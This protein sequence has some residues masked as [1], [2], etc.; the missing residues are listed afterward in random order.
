MCVGLL[1]GDGISDRVEKNV[2]YIIMLKRILIT[3]CIA[4]ILIVLAGFAQVGFRIRIGLELAN[5]SMRYEQ[6]G[7]KLGHILFAGDSTVVGT[8][9]SDPRYSVAGRFGEDFPR[10]TIDNVAINGLRLAKFP[11][12]LNNTRTRYDLVMMQVGANDVLRLH[13]LEDLETDAR[14]AVRAAKEK[15]E[16]VIWMTVGNLGATKFFPWPVRYYYEYWTRKSR[17]VFIRVAEEEGVFYIDLFT[18]IEDD[19]FQEDIERFYTADKLHI[20]DDGYAVWYEHIRKR[21]EEEGIDL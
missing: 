12:T 7:D 10:Y 16:K 13:D 14:V 3:I 2:Y 11:E 19:P 4:L 17:D 8:G 5:N 20:S 18:P 9:T 21:M 6:D 1:V 15:S